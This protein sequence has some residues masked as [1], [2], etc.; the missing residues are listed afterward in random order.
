[1]SKM[2]R[3]LDKASNSAHDDLVKAYKQQAQKILNDAEKLYLKLEAGQNLTV[4]ELFRQDR[5]YQLLASIN[6][7]LQKLGESEVKIM[8]QGMRELYQQS[9]QFISPFAIVDNNMVQEVIDQIW[10]ADGK[11]WSDRIWQ[12]KAELQQTLSDEL[13]NCVI[14]GDS[15][16]KLVRELQHRFDVSRHQSE[17]IART[18]LNRIQNRGAMAGYIDAGY[19]MYEFITAH[20]DRTCDECSTLDGQVFYFRDAEEGVNFPPMHPNCRSNIVGYRKE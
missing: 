13:M 4:A 10:C 20:D 12:H 14:R 17:C 15:H 2:T 5:Y 18:E 16:E 8:R 19:E 6:R 11:K 1:M 3:M 7:N 9:A